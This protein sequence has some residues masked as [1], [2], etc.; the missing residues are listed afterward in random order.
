MAILSWRDDYAVGVSAIDTEHR[1]LFDLVNAFHDAHLGSHTP[2]DISR[3]LS[4]LLAYA[5]THFRHEEEI[6]ATLGF[7]DLARHA[8]LHEGLVAALFE[9]AERLDA[10]GAMAET[11]VRRFM[12]QWL[13]EHIVREDSA[14]GDHLRRRAPEPAAAAATGEPARTPDAA[15]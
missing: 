7:P 9:F 12:Q 4:R 15:K 5:E 3:A 14:I 13:V 1:Y 6:Q 11:Q 10:D 2:A 8:Q